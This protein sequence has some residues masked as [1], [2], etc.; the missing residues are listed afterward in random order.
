[1]L[2][3]SA[4][5]VVRKVINEEIFISRPVLHPLC[6]RRHNLA[7]GGNQRRHITFRRI[8]H[9]PI[10]AS[11]QRKTAFPKIAD[12]HWGIHQVVVVSGDK[13]VSR[14]AQLRQS[15]RDAPISWKIVE[16]YRGA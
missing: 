15:D 14:A 6:S 2:H 10:G 11:R 7:H 16:S 13:D 1:M 4:I 8:H 5:A 3:P 9:Y 12:F